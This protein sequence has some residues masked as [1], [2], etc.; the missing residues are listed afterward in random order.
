MVRNV[1]PLLPLL[2]VLGCS[3]GSPTASPASG[4]SGASGACPDTAGAWMITA[5]CDPSLIGQSVTVTQTDCSL[6]FAAPFDGF[7]G[8]VGPD[9]KVVLSGPQSCTGTAS[10]SS[11]SM[12]CTPG[13]CPVKLAR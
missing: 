12:T 8:T 4:D 13:T 6:S 7:T 11:I 5:H 9:G 1:F 3:S 10:A 2:L